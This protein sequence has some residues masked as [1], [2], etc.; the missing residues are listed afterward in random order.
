[1]QFDAHAAG[2]FHGFEIDF[3]DSGDGLADGVERSG[4]VVMIGKERS[5]A[6]R[7]RVKRRRKEHK[8]A[9][10]N[11]KKRVSNYYSTAGHRTPFNSMIL[12]SA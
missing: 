2:G 3:G 11:Q 12:D 6:G 1:M 10:A 4:D 9:Q 5:G 8:E 7:L